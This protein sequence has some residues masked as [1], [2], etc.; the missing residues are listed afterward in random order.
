[1]A[2]KRKSD[3]NSKTLWFNCTFDPLFYQIQK[4]SPLILNS[5]F[6]VPKNYISFKIQD[7]YMGCKPPH[8]EQKITFF[9][10]W[11]YGMR[12]KL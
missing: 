9:G 10:G 6:L 1:M 4:D 12:P 7:I 3:Q 11:K 2:Q 8:L 5:S